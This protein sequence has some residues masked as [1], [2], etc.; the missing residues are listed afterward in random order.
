MRHS[1]SPYI[2]EFFTLPPFWK[3]YANYFN[4]K[5]KVFPMEVAAFY[6]RFFGILKRFR[7]LFPFFL[8]Y[9]F[10]AYYMKYKFSNALT[11]KGRLKV[12][13]GK[14]AIII[15]NHSSAHDFYILAGVGARLGRIAKGLISEQDWKK[16][17]YKIIFKELGMVP[18][19]G[20]GE[21]I[22]HRMTQVVENNNILAIAPEGTYSRGLVT[23]AFTGFLR[24]YFQANKDQYRVPIIPCFI[25]GLAQAYPWKTNDFV[26]FGHPRG[27][28]VIVHIGN[29][30]HIK[31][32]SNVTKE[33]LRKYAD[34][35]MLKIARMGGQ[36]QLR[37]NW[38]LAG[39][40]REGRETREFEKIDGI[41]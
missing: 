16:P 26:K 41:L 10:V 38:K 27:N 24:V 29:P 12:P 33:I 30:F 18:R 25:E 34:L 9:F 7:L 4:S 14:P 35:V 31:I 37:E 13:W 1:S 15:G 17:D 28:K 11:I 21:E 40:H 36:K 2:F 23:H 3:I 19:M 32:P 5:I 22:V 39:W 20:T 8:L 6:T